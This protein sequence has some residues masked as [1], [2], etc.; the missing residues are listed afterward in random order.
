MVNER[1]RVALLA[2]PLT[3]HLVVADANTSRRTLAM[4]AWRA[5]LGNDTVTLPQARTALTDQK[6]RLLTLSAA[7][8]PPQVSHG[9]HPPNSMCAAPKAV[10]GA[11]ATHT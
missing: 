11:T 5:V 8:H 9:M 7:P 2:P 10:S 3:A 1:L 4:T 6:S